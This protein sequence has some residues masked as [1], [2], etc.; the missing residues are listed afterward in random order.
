MRKND[1]EAIVSKNGELWVNERY[2][3]QKMGHSHSPVVTNKYDTM[4]KKCEI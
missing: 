2:L 3:E 1:I 4:C